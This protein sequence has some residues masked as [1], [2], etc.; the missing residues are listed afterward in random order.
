MTISQAKLKGNLGAIADYFLEANADLGDYYLA[1][2]GEPDTA[3]PRALGTLAERLGLTGEVTAEHLLRLLDGRHP[4]TGRRLVAYRKDRVAGVDQTASAP[5]SVSV[6]WAIGDAG[7]RHA[8]EQAQDTAVSVMAEYMQ[9]RCPL[10]RDHGEP[11]LATDVLAVAVNHHTSRQTEEQAKRGTAPDPQL[12]T[13]VLWMFAERQDGRLC[14]IYR[15]GIWKNRIEWEAAYHCALATE[16]ARAGFPIERMTG[17]GGRYFEIAGIPEKLRKRWSGRSVEVTEAMEKAAAWFREKHGREASLIELRREVVKSRRRKLLAQKT[18]LRHYWRSVAAEL[19][20]FTPEAIALLRRSGGPPSEAE[21]RE[22]VTRELLGPDGL[23]K[24]DAT[25]S[26][27]DLRVAALRHG[28]GLLDVAGVEQLVLDLQRS[29]ELK[30]TGEDRWT[31]RRMWEMEQGVLLWHEER[32]NL[33][34]TEEPDA[35]LPTQEQ[36]LH[37]AVRSARGD[38]VRLSVEQLEVLDEMLGNRTTSVRGWA[39]SG[40]GVVACAAGAI[41]RSQQR[42][43]TSLAVAGKTAAEL[44]VQLGE[45]TEHMT[46]EQFLRRCQKGWLQVRASDVIVL[47]EASMVS[48]EQ[49]H[50]L[51]KVIGTAGRLVMLGDEAQLGAIPAGGLWPLLSRGAPELTEVY[52]TRLRWERDAWSSLRHGR[53]TEALA[54]YAGHGRLR[55]SPTR[56]ESLEQAVRDWAR[57]GRTGL[58]ITDASNAER[59]WLNRAAQEHRLLAGDL[60]PE[61]VTVERPQG[62]VTFHRGDRVLFTAACRPG[63]GRRIENGTAA[64]VQS[65]DPERGTL[66]VETA[67]ASRRQVELRAGDV[68]LELSYATHVYKAQGTTVDRTYVITGGWQTSKESL[69]VACS[70]S[71]EGTRLYLD[72]E[73]LRHDI[74][75]SAIAEAAARGAASRA[76]VAGATHAYESGTEQDH[77]ATAA[78]RLRAMHRRKARRERS[79][80]RPLTE[81]HQ[82]R[83]DRQEALREGRQ[84]RALRR[85]AE[86]NRR[87]AP[88]PTL[89]TI[90]AMEGVPVWAL[91]VAQLVTGHSYVAAYAERQ[92]GGPVLVAD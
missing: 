6:A 77:Y 60:G 27:R 14:A 49:W 61:G 3:P 47:D 37:T 46:I 26:G 16:L 82:K 36:L 28:A 39:G 86:R 89:D 31:T 32:L 4:I 51:A 18:D 41:W 58:L 92:A 10:V 2:D 42:R 78:A 50:R 79:D 23:T 22:I 12:H 76:K 68:P 52:R 73:S 81:R 66:T 65:V 63:A 85:M 15:D 71:R 87:E 70:R 34:V 74:D 44:A 90:A 80:R 5:K 38:T 30:L 88:A 62:T 45:G 13:H 9:R 53:S 40:K 17:K 11:Q 8:V 91:E 59:D 33:E 83:K 35:S 69:Y 67:E 48:T 24:S 20:T 25:F 56:A 57:D 19:H 1:G 54:A 29:G 72:K 84:R 21:A 75:E 7:E 55:L 64:T 43:V